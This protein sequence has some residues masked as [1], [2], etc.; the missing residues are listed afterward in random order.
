VVRGV[1]RVLLARFFLAADQPDEDE[2][3]ELEH[4]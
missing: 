2:Q 1:E 4:L 3:I